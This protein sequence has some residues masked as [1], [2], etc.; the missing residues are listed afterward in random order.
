M[1]GANLS[2][3]EEQV[4]TDKREGDLN[5]AVVYIIL[6]LHSKLYY[7]IYCII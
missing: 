7:L 2:E 4:F 5:G 6:H 3:V 1:E